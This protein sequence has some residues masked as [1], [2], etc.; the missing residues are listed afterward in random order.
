MEMIRLIRRLN[1]DIDDVVLEKAPKMQSIPHQLFK[2][3]F[4]TFSP[5]K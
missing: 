5:T 4:C 2:K 1:V 3:R